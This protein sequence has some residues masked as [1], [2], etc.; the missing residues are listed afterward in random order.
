MPAP[1][2]PDRAKN[3]EMLKAFGIAFEQEFLA[4]AEQRDNLRSG[5]VGRVVASGHQQAPPPS[6]GPSLPRPG[7]RVEA[8]L[9]EEK[10][11]KGGWKARHVTSNISG[12][13]VNSGEVPADKKVGDTVTL[14]VQSANEREIAF[15]WPTAADE[16]RAQKAQGKPTRG[17]GGQRPRGRR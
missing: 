6:R 7:E 13:I 9:L 12:P 16:Q 8:V 11:R 15:R 1:Y 5:Q 2:L 17:P 3:V 10:T 14:I 4:L